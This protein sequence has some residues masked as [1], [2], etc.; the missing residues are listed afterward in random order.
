MNEK[1]KLNHPLSGYEML[2]LNPDAL[3]I[4]YEDLNKINNVYELFKDKNK[5]LKKFVSSSL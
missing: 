2:K 4:T 1:N 3:L 5:S